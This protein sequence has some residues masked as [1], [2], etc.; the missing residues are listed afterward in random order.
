MTFNFRGCLTLDLAIT[1]SLGFRRA[2]RQGS[3]V[4]NRQCVDF[5]VFSHR[6]CLTLDLAVTY[7]LGFRRADVKG[8]IL[9]VINALISCCLATAVV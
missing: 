3:N 7:S 5:M 8:Q 2:E 9:Q 6:G 1:Y 4:A